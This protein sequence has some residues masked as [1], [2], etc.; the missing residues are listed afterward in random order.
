[1]YSDK[2]DVAYL[3]QNILTLILTNVIPENKIPYS[4]LDVRHQPLWFPLLAFVVIYGV[5]F[6]L[7]WAF[8]LL[9]RKWS[10]CWYK[11]IAT[12]DYSSEQR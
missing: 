9:N 4:F 6:L 1:M 8:Y 5:G 2:G 12:Q 7:S 10:W 3:L 11:G